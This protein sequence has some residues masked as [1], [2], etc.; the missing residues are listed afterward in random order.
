MNII[1][2]VIDELLSLENIERRAYFY[3]LLRQRGEVNLNPDKLCL[4]VDS[5]YSSV[6]GDAA[7]YI[8]SNIA[9]SV[10][11]GKRGGENPYFYFSLEGQDAVRLLEFARM[12]A[13]QLG[14]EDGERDYLKNH[15]SDYVKALLI[16][17]GVLNVPSEEGERG[18]L[19]EVRM[20]D[21]SSA[22][23]VCAALNGAG[24]AVELIERKSD[25]LI[26]TRK[27]EEAYNL[28]VLAGA[29]ECALNLQ[30]IMLE[31]D[32]KS[33]ANR[34]SNFEMHNLQ[35]SVDCAVE[36]IEAINYLK[37][38]SKLHGFSEEDIS[39]LQYRVDN[40]TASAGDIAAALQV[41]KSKVFRRL[42]KAIDI[43]GREREQTK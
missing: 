37:D 6:I 15:L 27:G 16:G 17:G 29:T 41:S 13:P 40:P 7:S 35:K 2:Q 39:I 5:V 9:R 18:Y 11:M 28:L 20:W 30:N 43:A 3:A 10:D 38:N 23:A 8:K 36:Q 4:T 25:C 32:A 12:P 19:A 42:Q 22:K 31:Q 24:V 21:I 33:L 1:S 14:G 26:S 34:R